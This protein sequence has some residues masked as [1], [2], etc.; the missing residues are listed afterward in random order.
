MTEKQIK[1]RTTHKHDVEV[2]WKKATNFIPLAGEIIVYD[3][4][5][6]H[7]QIRLKMGDGETKVNDLPFY[8]N[9]D[10]YF[11][12]CETSE[13]IPT[14]VITLTNSDNFELKNDLAITIRFTDGL[15]TFM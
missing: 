3:T 15:K 4:D 5:D 10:S 7:S 1:S 11:G 2:N 9:N 8:T 6:T 12:I 14:K 13:G